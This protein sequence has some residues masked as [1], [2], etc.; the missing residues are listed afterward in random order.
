MKVI[1]LLN[2]NPLAMVR[3]LRE[4]D[5]LVKVYETITPDKEPVCPFIFEMLQQPDAPEDYRD[6]SLTVG[7][8]I[9]IDFGSNP[10]FLLSFEIQEHGF[11]LVFPPARGGGRYGQR[12]A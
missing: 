11:K 3:G 4:G 2:Q 7:D 9:S 6:R 12:S 8:V 10:A 5:T 1:V